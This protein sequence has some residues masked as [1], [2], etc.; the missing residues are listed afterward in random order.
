M[1]GRY[2]IKISQ[3]KCTLCIALCFKIRRKICYT[4][5]VFVKLTIVLICILHCIFI[6]AYLLMTQTIKLHSKWQEKDRPMSYQHH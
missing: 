3:A 2:I 1:Y 5:H 6:Q 4:V